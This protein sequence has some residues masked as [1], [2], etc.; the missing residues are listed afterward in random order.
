MVPVTLFENRRLNKGIHLPRLDEN[1][2]PEHVFLRWLVRKAV[3]TAF[4][5]LCAC[6]C[7]EESMGV[8]SG[9]GVQKETK[10][11][12]FCCCVNIYVAKFVLTQSRCGRRARELFCER[13]RVFVLLSNDTQQSRPMR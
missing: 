5:G 4:E 10:H 2:A 9:W 1:L 11:C 12:V 6:V 3:C 13:W 7:V 8:M